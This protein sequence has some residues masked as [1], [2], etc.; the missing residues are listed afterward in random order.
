MKLALEGPAGSGKTTLA[1]ALWSRLATIGGP[2]I[3]TESIREAAKLQGITD[4]SKLK[5]EERI[6]LQFHALGIQVH[7]ET[8]FPAFISDRS[9]ASYCLYFSMLCGPSDATRNYRHLA[10][11]APGYDLL[12]YV[13]PY[14][15]AMP[16]NDGVRMDANEFVIHERAAFEKWWQRP[17]HCNS[18]K[19]HRL[20]SVTL[21][22]RVAEVLEVIDQLKG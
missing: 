16:E 21:K 1:K 22:D 2:S 5:L 9:T 12:I 20:E 17:N 18:R 10:R 3:I 8:E 19:F 11:Q 7:R 15:E 13:P 4:L 6:G 14:S